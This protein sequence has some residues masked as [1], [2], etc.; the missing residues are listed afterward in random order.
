MNDRQQIN[1]QVAKLRQAMDHYTR[2]DNQAAIHVQ[3]M[4]LVLIAESLAVLASCVDT[5]GRDPGCF[6]IDSGMI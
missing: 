4:A 6:R 5:N 1:S 2:E 3:T